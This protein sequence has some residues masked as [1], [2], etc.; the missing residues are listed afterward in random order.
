MHYCNQGH[1]AHLS[2]AM[3]FPWCTHHSIVTEGDAQRVKFSQ[4]A[5]VVALSLGTPQGLPKSRASHSAGPCSQILQQKRGIG[6]E[7]LTV[8]QLLPYAQSHADTGKLL[9]RPKEFR[10]L[11]NPPMVSCAPDTQRAIP[12]LRLRTTKADVA[13]ASIKMREVH[14]ASSK[15]PASSCFCLQL[16]ALPMCIG[17]DGSSYLGAFPFQGMSLD[18]TATCDHA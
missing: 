7:C 15:G 18:L 9:P 11:S 2:P 14:P 16:E 13:R 8:Q 10:H 17:K 5:P 3:S 6:A 12:I 1:L 4:R